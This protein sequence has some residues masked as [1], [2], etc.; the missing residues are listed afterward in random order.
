MFKK[1]HPVLTARVTDYNHMRKPTA[2]YAFRSMPVYKQTDFQLLACE[3]ST[4]VF[5]SSTPGVRF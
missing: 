1:S 3:L 2:T 5:V 4:K